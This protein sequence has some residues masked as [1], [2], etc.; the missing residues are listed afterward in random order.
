MEF[1][2][3]CDNML[4]LLTEDN[5]TLRKHCKACGWSEV[6]PPGAKR[7]ATTQYR[8]DDLL[9]QQYQN[10]YLRYDP[11]L[12][13]ISDPSLACPIADCP[14]PKDHPQ[15]IYIKYNATHQKFLY[16][17]EYCGYSWRRE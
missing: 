12:P 8:E 1:C 5:R 10:P 9:Y 7:V 15:V 14:G 2:K 4:Y 6:V 13:R 3:V 16:M 17:C 11:T